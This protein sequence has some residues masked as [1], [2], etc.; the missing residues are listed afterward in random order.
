MSEAS[1]AKNGTFALGARVTPD[2]AEGSEAHARLDHRIRTGGGAA[3]YALVGVTY[4]HDVFP[5][6]RVMSFYGRAS[7]P[8]SA[9]CSASMFML[10]LGLPIWLGFL[11]HALLCCAINRRHHRNS[12]QS[13]PLLK[14]LEQHLY[15]LLDAPP[16]RR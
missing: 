6:R 11:P 2:A 3:I 14:S 5:P 9:A 16:P 1:T 4:K 7:L 12:S 13:G 8:C 10:K 15:V